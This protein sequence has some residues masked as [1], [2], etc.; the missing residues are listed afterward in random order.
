[1]TRKYI[2]NGQTSVER[3]EGP[4]GT[5]AITLDLYGW[6]VPELLWLIG[7]AANSLDGRTREGKRAKAF[8]KE[9]RKAVKELRA[10]ARDEKK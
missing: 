2:H 1:M 6:P 10:E 3:R 5:E 4:Y 7:T 9:L 8:W